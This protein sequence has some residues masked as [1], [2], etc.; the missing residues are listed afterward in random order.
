MVIKTLHGTK[1]YP[2][3]T[4]LLKKFLGSERKIT[5][6]ILKAKEEAKN[7]ISPPGIEPQSEK[8][9]EKNSTKISKPRFEPH[10]QNSQPG[11]EP[12]P[13]ESKS[14]SESAKRKYY[15]ECMT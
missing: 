13:A 6:E 15:V 8:S 14:K 7:S 3:N 1:E 12:G 5:D 4:L 2:Y 9:K 11:F 10:S